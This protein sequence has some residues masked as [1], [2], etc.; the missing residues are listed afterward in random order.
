MG[1]S[2]EESILKAGRDRMRPI[3]MTATT[4]IIG[5]LPLALGGSTVAGLFYFP[6][7]RTVMGGL[8]SSAVLTLLALPYISLGMEGVADWLRRIWRIWRLSAPGA[9]ARQLAAAG[10]VPAP[11]HPAP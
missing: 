5:L 4:T 10:I 9:R 6:M 2:R 7:A 1:M 3:L 8:A 11:T